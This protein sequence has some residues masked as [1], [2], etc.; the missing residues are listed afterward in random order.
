MSPS[1]QRTKSRGPCEDK[2]LIRAW[3]GLV[4]IGRPMQGPAAVGRMKAKEIIAKRSLALVL[5]R[6]WIPGWDLTG[7]IRQ[8]EHSATTSDFERERS[9]DFSC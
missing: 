5:R 8:N 7:A 3:G 6:I 9:S 4:E 1:S 2:K